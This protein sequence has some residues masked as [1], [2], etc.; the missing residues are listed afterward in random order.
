[1]RVARRV[2]T[3]QRASQ[4]YAI[5]TVAAEEL[6]CRAIFSFGV[7]MRNWFLVVLLAAL[8]AVA[9]AQDVGVPQFGQGP[10]RESKSEIP[11]IVGR[12]D[13][14]LLPMQGGGDPVP[15]V[16][17][18][19]VVQRAL[20]ADLLN[21]PSRISFSKIEWNSPNLTLRLD[22]YDG[23]ISA[24][25]GDK[26]CDKLVGTY[27]RPRGNTTAKFKFMASR[28]PIELQHT[29]VAWN[30]LTMEG[31]WT[32]AF[33]MPETSNERVAGARFTQGPAE[34]NDKA[35]VDAEVNGTISPVSGDFGL[36]HGAIIV[37][38]LDKKATKLPRFTMS[39]FDGIHVISMKGQLL[40]DGSMAGLITFSFGKPTA[41]TAKRVTPAP[42]PTGT[43]ALPNP[44]T[45]TT[46]N[47][48]SQVFKFS[49]ID[50]AT[51]KTVTNDDPLFKG[52]PVIVD[53]FGTWCPNCH[54]EAP[55]LADLYNHY[56]EKGLQIGGLSY[57]Y[58]ADRA[59]NTRLVKLYR[60]TYNIQFPLLLAGTTDAG[61]VAKT[62]PQLVNFWAY[63]TTIF[64]DRDGRVHA[65]HAGFAGPAT[66]NY[67]EVKARFE[68]IVDEMTKPAEQP[69][70]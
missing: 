8:S 58:T 19:Q 69:S 45:L 61:Q 34:G 47:D 12:W 21:G 49:G 26:A 28:H 11:S 13:S 36:M 56:R 68:Q 2:F 16:I 3:P 63:P 15:F 46:V 38:S 60:E 48:Q 39:R 51:G 14:Q 41:F 67:A 42:Q 50:P 53:I 25:C 37:D 65:I 27:T 31:N 7:N 52:K 23:T 4:I 66:G 43:P 57:E 55:L 20:R 40:P 62:M 32:F 1:M 64:I 10:V 29:P 33:D 54:D 24:R 5:R 22:Q 70:K 30:W 17:A 9:S 18:I 59:R 6:N 35:G 44:E